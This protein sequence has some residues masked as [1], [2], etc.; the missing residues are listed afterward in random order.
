MNILIIQL[1]ISTNKCIYKLEAS[2]TYQLENSFA[3][4]MPTFPER[5]WEIF[6]RFFL[7]IQSWF[8]PVK[9]VASVISCKQL[10]SLYQL[11]FDQIL[12]VISFTIGFVSQISYS[13]I[14]SSPGFLEP[15]NCCSSWHSFRGKILSSPI[16]G[17]SHQFKH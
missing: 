3:S 16:T 7:C 8:F 13:V 15:N 10:K 12:F 14:S 17:K 2:G 11:Y 1:F 6:W 9:S 5:W 4:S